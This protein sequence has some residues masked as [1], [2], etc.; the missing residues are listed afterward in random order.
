[1]DDCATRYPIMLVHGT[2]VSDRRNPRCWGRI[3]DVLTDRGARVFFGRQDAWGSTPN[4]AAQLAENV[5]K[6]LVE[7]GGDK[8]NIIA[9][10]K[11][12]LDARTL[13]HMPG[14]ADKIASIT[15]ISTPH[16]GLG[17]MSAI[18]PVA[19]YFIAVASL[20]VYPF[21]RLC[22][23]DKKPDPYRLSKVMT[24]RGTE[25]LNSVT[26][27]IP[28]IYYQSYAGKMPPE[29]RTRL[30]SFT[31]FIENRHGD[32]DGMVAV[33]SAKWG[34]FRGI[35][36]GGGKRGLSH[37]DEIDF[38][39]RDYEGNNVLRDDESAYTSVPDIYV[40]IVRDLKNR[41]F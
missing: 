39:K 5:D 14:Y 7:S 3:P 41:D 1:M 6:A 4:N 40:R 34:N 8:V 18:W 12:G 31:R 10:S 23:G 21:F 38:F 13:A 9:H 22:Y 27:D 32:N 19:R 2:G 35:F 29:S 24:R 11:G 16:R 15:T 26:P 28:S 20:F 37:A 25:K 30:F 33:E 17:W 36:T